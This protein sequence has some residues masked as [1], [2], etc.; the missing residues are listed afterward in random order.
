MSQAQEMAAGRSGRRSITACGTRYPAAWR[1]S[2]SKRPATALMRRRAEPFIQVG[3][4]SNVLFDVFRARTCFMSALQTVTG[5][6]W[7]GSGR[8]RATGQSDY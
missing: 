2:C 6:S 4:A 1:G 7:S 8:Y 5:Y 3:R